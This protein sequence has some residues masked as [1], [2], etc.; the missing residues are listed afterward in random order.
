M[1]DE[2][3]AATRAGHVALVGRPNAG[4]SS[5]LNRLLGEKLSIVTPAAQTTR[6]RVLGI[7]TREGV[8]AI[9]VDTPGILDP[10][11]L[12]HRSM[13][14]S[15]V[16][17]LPDADAVVLV[18]DAASGPPRIPEEVAGLL[19]KRRAALLVAANKLDQ[20]S[21][22]QL[23]SVEEWAAR[24]FGA[25]TLR[26]SA[27]T[28]EGMEALRAALA[29]R[30]P[31]SPFLYPEDEISSQPVRFFVTELIREAV[32]ELYREE[33]PYSFAAEIEE[34]REDADPIFIRA[35]LFVERESQKGILI[36]ARGAGIRQLGELARQ[37]IEQFLGARVYLDLWVKV[38]PKWRK[39]ARSLKRLGFNLP[40]EEK[41]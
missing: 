33:L 15:V 11:Y 29:E 6:T 3:H 20:A 37:K 34:F 1:T 16:E 22:D 35:G 18:V 12:L 31:L 17:L 36:G 8:Q 28:G 40:K 26:V 10:K 27:A 21:E 30:L 7:D 41:R 5:I 2:E 25:E 13:V 24:E 38:L 32:F 39:D 9:Y 14:Q 19:R 23:G 4:K